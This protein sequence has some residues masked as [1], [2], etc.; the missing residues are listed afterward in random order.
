M[1]IRQGSIDHLCGIYSVLNATEIVVGKYVVDRRM[2][3]KS[4]QRKTL[5]GELVAHLAAKNE[6]EAALTTGIDDVDA[7]LIDVAV[8]SV[9][10]YQGQ[11]MRKCPA[12]DTDWVPLDEYWTRLATHL[13]QPDSAAIICI[14]GRR[15]HWTCVKAVTDS[16]LVLADS[17]GMKQIGRH[18]CAVG[19]EDR[20]MYSLW[21]TMTHLLSIIDV[22]V[23]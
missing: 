22:D 1:T 20:G 13:E 15:E 5:F 18:D 3:H 7:G 21:P 23:D 4:S 11:K 14:S 17:N 9:K 6:L 10:T 8:K 2:G 12:F 16:A 19:T